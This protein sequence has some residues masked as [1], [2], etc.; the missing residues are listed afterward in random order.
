[1]LLVAGV[2]WLIVFWDSKESLDQDKTLD[3][4]LVS[5]KDIFTRQDFAKYVYDSDKDIPS[6]S[7][8]YKKLGRVLRRAV[9]QRKIKEKNPWENPRR[10]QKI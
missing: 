2:L 5:H 9:A 3:N 1:M 4:F 6:S 10:Y 8:E 7:S